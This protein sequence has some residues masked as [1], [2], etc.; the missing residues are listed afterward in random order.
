M[1]KRKVS[2][3]TLILLLF[4]I[5]A[6][7]TGG[8]QAMA[9]P[10]E[11]VVPDS[12]GRDGGLSMTATGGFDEMAKLGVWTPIHVKIFT[13]DDISGEIQVEANL[14][15]TRRII[16]AKPVQLT[17]RHEHE[18]SFEVPVVS[19]KRSVLIRLVQGKKTL[20]ETEVTFKR[21][22]PP[23]I[24]LIGVLSDD[25]E[26]F[27]FLNGSVPVMA[28]WYGYEKVKMMMAAGVA[29][30]PV[31]DMNQ[32]YQ[33]R[34]AVVVPL[35][36]NTFPEKSE[37]MDSFSHII[38]NQFDTSLLSKNQLATLENW[39]NTGGV[40]MLGTGL[41]WQKV[42]HGLPDSLKPF[43]ITDTVDVSCDT[44]L[45]A[46]T[47]RNASGLTLRLAR[48]D[49]GFEYIPVSESEGY[50]P[51]E[52]VRWFDN[53]IV[54]GNAKNPLALKYRK[55][56]GNVLVFTFD[57]AAEPFVSWTG[58]NTFFE[59]ALKFIDSNI[60]RVYEQGSGFYQRQQY[61]TSNL[62]YLATE[63]PDDKKVPF[64]AMFITLGIYVLLAGPVLYIILKEKDKRDLA[65]IC[66][67]ALSVLFLVGMYVL[68]FKSRYHSAITNTVSLL[69]VS[70]GG[71]QAVVTSTI[72]VFNDRRGLLKLQ[73]DTNNGMKMPFLQGNDGYYRYYGDDVEGSVIGKYTMGD[74][75]VFEQYDVMLWT[76]MLLNAEKTVP[77]G[78]DLLKDIYLKDSTLLG[79][80]ANTTPY[81]LLDVAILVGPN[82]I[83]VGDILAGET[84]EL[85]IDLDS[86]DVYKRPE[87]Y[88]DDVFGWYYY[89]YSNPKDIPQDYT[90]RM[91]RR[92]L[93]ENYLSEVYNSQ[94]GRTRF[95]LLARNSQIID[96]GITVNDKEPQKYNRNLIRVDSEFA[97]EP[98]KEMEIP[99]GI[100]VP[101]MYQNREVGWQDSQ[102]TIRINN[103]GDLEFRFVLPDRL[104]VTGFELSVETYIPTY[105]QYNLQYNNGNMQTQIL[106][107]KYEYYLYNVKTGQWDAIHAKT[108]IAQD[109]QRYIGSG[110]EVRMKISVVE[111]GQATNQVDNN[112]GM[113]TYYEMELLSM[114]EIT[115]RGVAK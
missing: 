69:Q 36:R 9:T 46:F 114:P 95:V 86:H 108:D 58:K 8:L 82:I 16:L 47:E 4:T 92:R 67:P 23:E 73:Y 64:L 57:P 75:A 3:S 111:L 33:R 115:V 63:V 14:D 104:T 60:Q 89:S 44:D 51:G 25:P 100:I 78:A 41:N 96:Y 17:G 26:A 66:I 28:E 76:P 71:D 102:N 105:V 61:S 53:D 94:I 15:Q 85:H 59:N 48:G 29:V 52:P 98:G 68:G 38:I 74:P 99:G 6:L 21:L 32:P 50:K 93:F 83:P 10:P 24:L 97:F 31:P 34:Q 7:F 42:Y 109:L 81:D 37:V 103:T 22:L 39:V 43:A 40:L 72:G 90:Q 2:L 70:E 62:Q 19:A 113:Y 55:G 30:A 79:R 20:A 11:E 87:E 80:I 101:S 1:R 54:A 84:K 107:N 49:L 18:I 12:A 56:M 13:P 88:L 27:G 5:A 77:F 65:W 112:T 110:N 91:Q 45:N 106:T 35:D